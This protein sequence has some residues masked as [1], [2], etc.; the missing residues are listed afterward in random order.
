M[1]I[2]LMLVVPG[3]LLLALII[4]LAALTGWPHRRW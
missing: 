2:L 1:T 4:D 3:T